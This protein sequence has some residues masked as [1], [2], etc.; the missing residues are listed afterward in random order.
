MFP[1]IDIAMGRLTH[2][3]RPLKPS[4][5]AAKATLLNPSRLVR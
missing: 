1:I 4:A 2:L 5:A 3:S